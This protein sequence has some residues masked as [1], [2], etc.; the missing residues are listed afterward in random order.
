MLQVC[1]VACLHRRQGSLAYHGLKD[2][3]DVETYVYKTRTLNVMV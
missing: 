3:L 1:P 2:F